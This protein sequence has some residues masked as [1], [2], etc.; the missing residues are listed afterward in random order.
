MFMKDYISPKK[1]L[2]RNLE[3]LNGNY[4][5]YTDSQTWGGL[6]NIGQGQKEVKME[7]SAPARIWKGQ[8]AS[9]GQGIFLMIKRAL[10]ELYQ[11]HQSLEIKIIK[12]KIICLVVWCRRKQC[13]AAHF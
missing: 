4:K 10:R 5:K 3:H 1:N 12:M 9:K 13:M 2:P 11:C 7:H 6:N 8:G